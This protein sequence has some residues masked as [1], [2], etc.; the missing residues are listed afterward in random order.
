MLSLP[1]APPGPVTV[2]DESQPLTPA[3]LGES[4]PSLLGDLGDLSLIP[5]GAMSRS[6]SQHPFTIVLQFT[7]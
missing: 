3:F 6:E 5:M 4:G 7:H 2:S 1:A